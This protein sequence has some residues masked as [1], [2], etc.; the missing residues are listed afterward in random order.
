M[1]ITEDLQNTD[2]HPQQ[3]E[4]QALDRKTGNNFQAVY[5]FDRLIKVKENRDQ[6][7]KYDTKV[8]RRKH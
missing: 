1:Q 6:S 5:N 2:T 3:I 8:N 4:E 7:E